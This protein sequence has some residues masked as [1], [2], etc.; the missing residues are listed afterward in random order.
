MSSLNVLDL[1][2]DDVISLPPRL[3]KRILDF[4]VRWHRYDAALPIAEYMVAS[5]PDGLLYRSTIVKIYSALGRFEEASAILS[6]LEHQ[7]HDRP[8]VLAASG[9]FEMARKDLP[10]A[11]ERYLKMLEV[12]PSSP[13]AWRRL[14]SLYLAADQHGKAHA[15]CKKVLDYYERP[16]TDDRGESQAHPEVYRVLAG[17]YHARGD[18]I[19]ATEIESKLRDRESQEEQNLLSDISELKSKLS[20][21]TK[22][23]ELAPSVIEDVVS[24][25]AQ[26]LPVPPLPLE[27]MECLKSVFGYDCF[28]HCQEE[29]VSRILA[30][31]N[32]LVIMPTGAG[33]SLCY[34]LPAALGRRV[35]VISP[36]IAL[37]KDQ[38]DGLPDALAEKSTLINSTLGP[39]ELDKRMKGLAEGRYNLVYVA[40]ERLRQRP[41]LHALK[42]AGVDLFVVDEVHCVSA[43]G[44]DFR[45]DYLFIAPALKMLGNPPFCGMTATAGPAMRKEIVARIGPLA[46]V[47]AGVHRPNLM[48]EVKHV[49]N[50]DEKLRALALICSTALGSGIIYAN[51]RAQTETIALYLRDHGIDA[52]HYHA[53]M[54]PESRAAAQEAFMVGECRIMVA[55]VAFGMGVDKSDVRFV[56]HFSL[57][58][59]LENY[60]QEAGRAGRDGE[61]ARCIMLYSSAD[62]GRLTAFATAQ[63]VKI[64]DIQSV[65][66]AIRRILPRGAG[67]VRDEEIARLSQLDDTQIRV[68]ISILERVGLLKRHLDVPVTVGIGLRSGGG[69]DDDF[70]E[71]AN[72]A[73]IKERSSTTFEYMSLASRVSMP[74]HEMESL[75]LE[76]RSQH[77]VTYRSTGR[78]MYLELC[79]AGSGVKAGIQR[80]L[81]T[82]RD[83]SMRRAEELASYART[84]KCRHDFI[85]KHFGEAR[86]NDCK[87]CDNCHRGT[88]PKKMGDDHLTVLQG[89]V[90][91]P[92]RLGSAGLIKALRGAKSCPIQPHE[93][94]E[95]GVFSGRSEAAVKA[96]IEDLLAWGYLQPDGTIIR[97]LLT[98]T[99]AGRKLAVQGSGEDEPVSS[100]S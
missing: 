29:A 88:A 54:E 32:L 99:A 90:A 63:Q 71:F 55:T 35:V 94:A 2:L 58:K 72:R 40:P 68:S 8:N 3:R 13:K 6:D 50:S 46:T 67:P 66:E 96:I 12:N 11:L 45:P 75:I 21:V 24:E 34:Q 97:P 48:F 74:P 62:K 16:R 36:L 25:P 92:T 60:Y 33:K 30:K 4:F 47:S 41:F 27:A 28:R 79:R 80:M 56:V 15:F 95:L 31:Q 26:D 17:I 61:P 38:V 39:A 77:L 53:G 19:L 85:S 1:P 84:S 76:W 7:F 73:G 20:P 83:E 22:S 9:D 49:S 89:I 100:S 18:E 37:M 42:Q 57:P 87:S 82:Y 81:D 23:T 14:A 93:W 69:G 52:G 51:S 78:T 86:I 44:H 91:L 10:S 59:S 5:Q 70:I 65:Y 43:W 64:D 98:L